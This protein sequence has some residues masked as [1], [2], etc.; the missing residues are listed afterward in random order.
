M[1]D[2]I[3]TDTVVP[4]TEPL[5]GPIMAKRSRQRDGKKVFLAGCDRSAVEQR[6]RH[7]IRRIK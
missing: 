1:T 2:F 6:E 7:T 5:G 3:I 4:E